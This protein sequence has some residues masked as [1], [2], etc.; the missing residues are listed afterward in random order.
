MIRRRP[1]LQRM[2]PNK[3]VPSLYE[4]PDK[5]ALS[6]LICQRDARL[7]WGRTDSNASS[8][9][10]YRADALLR[11]ADECF[12]ARRL[13]CEYIRVAIFFRGWCIRVEVSPL[14]R[15]D[16][17]AALPLQLC[18]GKSAPLQ[19][20]QRRDAAPPRAREKALLPCSCV[21]REM[22]LLLYSPCQRENAVPLQL[23]QRRDVAPLQHL[24]RQKSGPSS[25]P[26]QGKTTY[27]HSKRTLL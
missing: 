12:R 18:Q 11:C 2:Y 17:S 26:C 25:Q 6:L 8:V 9:I 19:P 22:L 23:C 14:L 15:P 16:K 10:C 20:C 27:V 5:L 4:F 7:L 21:S 3:G 1:P 13:R 24:S